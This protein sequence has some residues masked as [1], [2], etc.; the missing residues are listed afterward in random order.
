[1]RHLFLLLFFATT[2]LI[3]GQ[4]KE[5]YQNGTRQFGNAVAVDG[6]WAVAGNMYKTINYQGHD[7]INGGSVSIYKVAP[8]GSWQH[9]QDIDEPNYLAYNN[10]PASPIGMFYGCD[11]DIKGNNIIVGAYGYDSDML[12]NIGPDGMA[13][14]Y[15]YNSGLNLWVKSATLSSEIAVV[16]QFG[17][18]VAIG[19]SYAVVGDPTEEHPLSGEL[20]DRDNI[21]CA[22]VYQKV[23]AQWVYQT[24]LTA[25]DGWGSVG[26]P[27]TGPGDQF[28]W[29]VDVDANLIAVGA[30][31]H[32]IITNEPVG[33][34]YLFEKDGANW[35]Q[36]K[37]VSPNAEI[38]SYF[39]A[40]LALHTNT[41][42]VG[43]PDS[44]GDGINAGEMAVFTNTGN[45]NAGMLISSPLE[46][47]GAFFGSSVSL[48]DDYYAI[49]APNY[50]DGEGMLFVYERSSGN[51]SPLQPSNIADGDEFGWSCDVTDNHLMVGAWK[52]DRTNANDGSAYWFDMGEA[53]NGGWT[54]ADDSNWNNPLNWADGNIPNGI[55]NVTISSGLVHYPIINQ[56]VATCRNLSVAALAQITIQ[57]GNLQVNGNLT[58]SG[59]IINTNSAQLT[60]LGN[61]IF[62]A[63]VQQNIPAGTFH[64][65]HYNSGQAS[66]LQGNVTF[67][68]KFYHDNN[69]NL[70]IGANTLTL[71]D[72][73]WGTARKIIF[74]SASSLSLINERPYDF[75]LPTNVYDLNNFTVNIPGNE[76][77]YI[78][79][80]LTIHGTMSLLDGDVYLGFDRTVD[81]TIHHPIV[82]GSGRLLSHANGGDSGLFIMDEGKDE[83][84]FNIP[85]SITRLNKLWIST[86]NN[87]RLNANL[88]IGSVFALYSAGFNAN[89]FDITY[90]EGADL[91]IGGNAIIS[92]E[93]LTG[94]NGIGDVTIQAGSPTFDF[95]AQINGNLTVAAASGGVSILP[96]RC[97]T[98]E[99]TTSLSA[100]LILKA[101]AT[102]NACFIDN[103]PIVIAQKSSANIIVE[104]WIPAKEE[105]HYISSPVQEATSQFFAGAW[106]NAY[107]PDQEKWVPFTNLSQP[108]NTMQGY[109]TKLPSSFSGQTITF[110]GVLNTARN[111]QITFPLSNGGDGYNLVGNPFPS[112]VDW[113]NAN[114]SRNQMANAIYLWD[115]SENRYA[116]YIN[117]AGVNG[118]TSQIP[119]MQGFFVLATGP[120]ASLTINNNDVRIPMPLDFYKS[121][122]DEK[123]KADQLLVSLSSNLGNDEVMVRFMEGATESFDQDF[124]AMKLFGK[125]DLP[126]VYIQNEHLEK[127]SIQTFNSVKETDVTRIGL[128]IQMSGIYSLK[129]NGIENFGDWVSITIEDKKTQG[130]YQVMEGFTYEFDYETNESPDRFVLHFKDAT[131][132]ENTIDAKTN[133]YY[134]QGSIYFA[135]K[136]LGGNSNIT[137]FNMAGQLV[138]DEQF[139]EG[140]IHSL[141]VQ[142]LSAGL[143]LVK[144]N[145][146]EESNQAKILIG[147]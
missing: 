13:F 106:L 7:Y 79:G 123:V 3:Y 30:T 16:N 97:I 115:A 117:G 135:N 6:D 61:T 14:I 96:G 87:S 129:F 131:G 11:V 143:Y 66:N 110:D 75:F 142:N 48:C 71:G 90:E 22:H 100:N 146:G 147:Q 10:N 85:A 53:A 127:M 81:L 42:L 107:S 91:W 21:G 138:A 84:V 72:N 34:V 113:D 78:N 69:K 122:A 59:Q 116:S 65:F 39:G 77:V 68:G 132:I 111:Q 47:E 140:E 37:L 58:N 109:S 124:D 76:S 130:F 80:N 144:I 83:V 26:G 74:S 54:G 98:V 31:R 101:N 20:D 38:D 104:A 23:G 105:W 56:V 1:M 108:L 51:F 137:L 35:I 70:T 46:A 27:A 17:F 60:V 49:G 125:D 8:D 114:W 67:L 63:A 43:I 133:I 50:G 9:F 126:Q 62:N 40:S 18:S 121:E 24:K 145:Q 136:G 33:A 29:S 95:D 120:G 64:E 134:H 102:G 19:D 28:G 82:T 141:R 139:G 92:E 128:K 2:T 103:G 99:G 36:E 86:Q 89:G 44:D 4:L 94:P 52:A 55:T 118:G 15:S 73:I 32:G 12:G 41:L 57:N 45:W 88:I 93:M 119:S 25:S 112:A 5:Q